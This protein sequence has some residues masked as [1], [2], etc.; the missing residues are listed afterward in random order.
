[1]ALIRSA[2]GWKMA[3]ILLKLQLRVTGDERILGDS[4]FVQS[5]IE[6]CYEDYSHRQ[7]RVAQGM[8]LKTLSHG[9]A[10]Y[11][12]LSCDQLFTPGR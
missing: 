1:L 4:E 6:R 9:V 10:D 3:K 2:C 7:R 12:C 8:D 11:F 5:V